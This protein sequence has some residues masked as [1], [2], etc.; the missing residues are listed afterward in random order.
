MPDSSREHGTASTPVGSEGADV[1]VRDPTSTQV[2]ALPSQV[3][4]PTSFSGMV[5]RPEETALEFNAGGLATLAYTNG[6]D[7][8]LHRARADALMDM[9]S[10]RLLRE[11]TRHNYMRIPELTDY[12][13]E[14]R[15]WLK[16]ALLFKAGY[17][18]IIGESVTATEDGRHDLDDL[19]DAVRTREPHR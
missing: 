13:S 4:D 10:V 5:Y 3:A 12:L 7:N 9:E 19:L 6:H 18:D 14:P 1:D 15:Q 11:L 8:W 16:L 17:A 2:S